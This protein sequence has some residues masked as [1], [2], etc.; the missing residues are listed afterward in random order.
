MATK[1]QPGYAQP[2][3]PTKAPPSNDDG[4]IINGN[5]IV[6]PS[7][8][9]Q[10]WQNTPQGR[11]YTGSQQTGAYRGGLL[12]DYRGGANTFVSGGDAQM[13]NNA[14]LG[15]ADSDVR[16]AAAAQNELDKET[17]GDTGVSSAEQLANLNMYKSRIGLKNSLA[18]QISGSDDM[19]KQEQDLEKMTAGQA[20]GQGIKTTRQN[21]NSRGLLYSGMREGGEQ[22]IRQA[23]S[24]QLA[25]TMAASAREGANAKSAAEN[26]YASVDLA[27]Q[28]EMLQRSNEAFDTANQNSIA[29]R[30]AMQQLGAGVGAAVGSLAGSA[31]PSGPTYNNPASGFNSGSNGFQYNGPSSGN[32]GLLGGTQGQAAVGG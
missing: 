9:N 30:Q 12:S 7:S 18:E 24:A 10:M 29:R 2:Q 28:Q 6:A 25:S 5:G 8:Q 31:A 1:Q 3:T 14:A 21:Y 15:D 27:N 26:A 16:G 23:G 13:R 22:N 4:F 32:Y 20:V 11:A 17:Q 19:V